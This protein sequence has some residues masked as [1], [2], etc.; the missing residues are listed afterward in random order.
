VRKLPVLVGANG[1]PFLRVKKPQP[2]FLTR[3]LDDKIARKALRHERLKVWSG[4]PMDLAVVEQ[5]WDEMLGMQGAREA[6]WQSVV[7]EET[8]RVAGL[9]MEESVRTGEVA[10]RMMDVLGRE[11]MAWEVEKMAKEREKKRLRRREW[12]RKK[13]EEREEERAL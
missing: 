7:E 11:T 5:A 4:V 6:K 12:R 1:F 3:V 8:E 2:P 10:R 13:R 9:L